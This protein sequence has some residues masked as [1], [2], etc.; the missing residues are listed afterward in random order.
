MPRRALFQIGY[1]SG[2]VET[3][4]CT[5]DR[6]FIHQTLDEY[7]DA[8]DKGD[9]SHKDDRF[10]V[11]GECTTHTHECEA[12]STNGVLCGHSEGHTGQHSWWVYKEEEYEKIVLPPLPPP[13]T[14]TELA[15]YRQ[16]VPRD[17]R[18]EE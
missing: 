4:T 14:E 7:L 12:E 16:Y 8:L 1:M 18:E 13:M 5:T 11:F 17:D 3:L 15:E 10:T 6:E 2:M 9:V